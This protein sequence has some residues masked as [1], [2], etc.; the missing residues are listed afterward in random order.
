MVLSFQLATKHTSKQRL[1][2]HL[3]VQTNGYR[4]YQFVE[5]LL[6]MN[7]Q[8]RLDQLNASGTNH[9]AVIHHHQMHGSGSALL[10]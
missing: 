2:H 4:R 10:F 7:P 9:V 1:Q 5:E 8:M 6:L 3:H